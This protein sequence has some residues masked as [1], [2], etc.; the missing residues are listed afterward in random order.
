MQ[1]NENIRKVSFEVKNYDI[2]FD[3]IN[4]GYFIFGFQIDF[5]HF[6]TKFD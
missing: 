4:N 3:S 2:L 6:E 5:I 1:G